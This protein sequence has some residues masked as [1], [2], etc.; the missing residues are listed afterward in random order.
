VA[1]QQL[2]GGDRFTAVAIV[3]SRNYLL[4]AT[5]PVFTGDT[6]NSTIGVFNAKT[7]NF[8]EKKSRKINYHDGTSERSPRYEFIKIFDTHNNDLKN[9]SYEIMVGGRLDYADDAIKD[10]LLIYYGVFDETDL[11]IK[12]NYN[13]KFSQGTNTF[14]RTIEASLG[15]YSESGFLNIL[16]DPLSSSNAISLIKFTSI[17]NTLPDPYIYEVNLMSFYRNFTQIN[18]MMRYQDN[19]EAEAQIHDSK[20]YLILTKNS[21]LYIQTINISNGETIA[22]VYYTIGNDEKLYYPQMAISDKYSTV[23]LVHKVVNVSP[24]ATPSED[25]HIRI[26]LFNTSDLTLKAES[27]TYPHNAT[28][29]SIGI[30]QLEGSE[31]VVIKG[32]LDDTPSS[33][34]TFSFFPLT[35][36]Q[37]YGSCSANG[38]LSLTPDFGNL[39]RVIEPVLTGYFTSVGP[40]PD[41]RDKLSSTAYE[42]SPTSLNR[43]SLC[44]TSDISPKEVSSTSTTFRTQNYTIVTVPSTSVSPTNLTLIY[45]LVAPTEYAVNITYDSTSVNFNFSGEYDLN[46]TINLQYIARV[47]STFYTSINY[48]VTVACREECTYC[49]NDTECIV[50]ADGFESSCEGYSSKDRTLV[51]AAS[52]V[53]RFLVFSLVLRSICKFKIDHSLWVVI[54]MFQAI[55]LI[56][57]TNVGFGVVLR[58]F[59]NNYLGG[60]TLQIGISFL[61]ASMFNDDASL[62]RKYDLYGIESYVFMHYFLS[63]V[64]LLM[65][66]ILLLTFLISILECMKKSDLRRS[67]MRAVAHYLSVN[68][69]IRGFYEYSLTLFMMAMLEIKE[70]YQEISI[71]SI[72]S[73]VILGIW[74]LIMF[75]IVFKIFKNIRQ[76]EGNAL[77]YSEPLKYT[78]TSIITYNILFLVK[79]LL[80]AAIV[81]F[82]ESADGNFQ[83]FAFVLV[84]IVSL[85][86]TAAF[87]RFKSGVT[88]LLVLL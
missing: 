82:F 24:T 87:V 67:L 71:L 20:I 44:S 15:C 1:T 14:G 86:V 2:V 26:S 43:L 56:T 68:I 81:T 45:E 60:F 88:M 55:K 4:F 9:T 73:K 33:R 52:G 3:P 47:N 32:K 30:L 21:D 6:L 16:E 13:Q 50:C 53:I 51:R 46:Q 38:S 17:D 59:L 74:M 48:T 78:I 76:E 57:L 22:N 36:T 80:F 66:V 84:L 31:Q 70:S 11:S 69:W 8:T 41:I 19:Y 35:H 39:V 61:P 5:G 10:T 65:T 75:L 42:T 63:T 83:V 34:F 18:W 72:S 62:K 27:F 85:V 12:F 23:F 58:D 28:A 7:D 29:Y 79:R 77:E 25:D 64:I 54:N 40:G 49:N 37:D